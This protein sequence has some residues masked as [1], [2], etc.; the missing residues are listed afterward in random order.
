MKSRM[1]LLGGLFVLVVA[2]FLDT[3]PITSEESNY[4]HISEDETVD[5]TIQNNKRSETST[6]EYVLDGMNEVDGYI[7]ESY[8]EYE[9]HQDKE[10]NDIVRIPT[11]NYQYLK[12]QKE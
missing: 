7:V 9:V 3:P 10:G 4:F 1:A 12:Y 6:Y 8:R 5:A 2:S 11:D